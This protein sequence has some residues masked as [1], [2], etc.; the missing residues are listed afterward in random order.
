[1]N[2][3]VEI[4]IGFFEEKGLIQ[5]EDHD[6]YAYGLDALLYTAISTLGLLFFGIAMHRTL[7]T[8]I[9]IV[10]FYTNQTLGGGFHASTHL[11][12]FLTMSIGLLC[13][14][15]TLYI[16]VP[17]LANV[18]VAFT[19]VGFM[20]WYPLVL[21]ENK[22]YLSGKHKLFSIRS[23]CALVFQ[24]LVFGACLAWGRPCSIQTV[25]I[26]LLASAFSRVTAVVQ[27]RRTGK[28]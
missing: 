22:K 23:R 17:M 24:L 6:V 10:I 16:P 7:E 9:L 27:Q 15:G 21:H 26:G 4:I 1:M 13:C 14:L 3:I 18:I 8:I 20:L 28:M 12:C 19:S 5:P 11:R 2:K 25:S